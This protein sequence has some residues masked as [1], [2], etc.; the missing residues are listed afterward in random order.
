MRVK[1]TLREPI[2][3]PALL[4]ED[5]E[6]LPGGERPN[7]RRRNNNSPRRSGG[8]GR[9]NDG[10]RP[11][12]RQDSRAKMVERVDRIERVEKL[13]VRITSDVT[14]EKKAAADRAARQQGDGRPPD[15][16]ATNHRRP[17]RKP[18]QRS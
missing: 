9:Q 12:R 2:Q 13:P 6:P 17:Y 5:R 11:D 4:A 10:K 16:K 14:A 15:T 7:N 1:R 8:K 18:R 3:V